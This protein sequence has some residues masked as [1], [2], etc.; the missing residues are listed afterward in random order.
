MIRLRSCRSTYTPARRPDDEAR[1]RRDDQGQPDRERRLGLRVD[2]D[3]RPPGRSGTIRPSRSAGPARGARN[4]ADGRP[5]TSTGRREAAPVIVSSCG[6]RPDASMLIDPR[7]T[8]RPS[9]DRWPSLAVACSDRDAL[10]QEQVALLDG[11]RSSRLAPAVAA[12][13]AEAAVRGDH[14]V[15]R[16]EQPDRVAARRRRRPR[17]RARRAD[18]SGDVAVARGPAPGDC[19]DRER[20]RAGP[21][22]GRSARSNRTRASA[23]RPRAGPRAQRVRGVEAVGV[24]VARPDRRARY[25][26]G[27]RR[28]ASSRRTRPRSSATPRRPRRA[29]VAATWNG[30]ARAGRVVDARGRA[31]CQHRTSLAQTGRWYTPREYD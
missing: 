21:R 17:G 23:G 1:D 29:S 5:R 28:R 2:Q 31:S 6:V 7:A 18:P 27:R 25:S 11:A 14:P 12:V 26:T 10:P 4:P 24:P 13:A 8:G 30:P 16:D 22:P 9:N 3:R 19:R 20:G 15:A